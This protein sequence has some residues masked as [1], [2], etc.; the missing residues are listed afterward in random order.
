MP[1]RW[2]TKPLSSNTSVALTEA[3]PSPLNSFRLY[4]KCYKSSPK[5]ISLILL[6]KMKITNMS[7][8]WD[9]SIVAWLVPLSK[10][11]RLWNLSITISEKWLWE[12][13]ADSSQW[14]TWMNSS[15]L[16]WRTKLFVKH[17]CLVFQNAK[18]WKIKTSWDPMW[19]KLNQN[20]FKSSKVR[21]ILS[22]KKIKDKNK[23][24]IENIKNKKN[25]GVFMI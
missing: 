21:K 8:H 14:Y 2:L 25:E 10:S 20:W 13:R 12:T 15:T 3:T 19:V 7:L 11:I 17:F 16:Y 23:I 4:L 22:L 6:S 24:M 9:F 5:K 18:I 1:S